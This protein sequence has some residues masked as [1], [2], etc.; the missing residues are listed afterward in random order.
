MVLFHYHGAFYD[1]YGGY[2]VDS[3]V[4]L[5]PQAMRLLFL[6]VLLH[7]LSSHLYVHLCVPTTLYGMLMTPFMTAAPHCTALRWV[8]NVTADKMAV[9]CTIVATAVASYV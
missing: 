9:V 5:T 8:M 4:F 2:I 7:V 1:D 6:F 3:D